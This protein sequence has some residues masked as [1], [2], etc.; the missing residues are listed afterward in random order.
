[1]IKIKNHHILVWDVNNL[2]GYAVSQNL[3]VDNFGR[4]ENFLNLMKKNYNEEI[5]EGYFLDVQYLKNLH[6]IYN[7]LPFLSERMELGKAEKLIYMIKMNM[8]FM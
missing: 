8:M 3:P 4:I 5:D 6:E 1:M 2:H 7:D